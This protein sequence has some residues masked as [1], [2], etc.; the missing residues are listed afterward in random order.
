[1]S[2]RDMCS[3]MHATPPFVLQATHAFL[4]CFAG[5][6]ASARLWIRSH[7]SSP[8]DVM[9]SPSACHS[10]AVTT[11]ECPA[12]EARGTYESQTSQ[13]CTSQSITF[14]QDARWR[15]FPLPVVRP[16]RAAAAA[17]PPSPSASAPS[18][19]IRAPSLSPPSP[20]PLRAGLGLGFGFGLQ[21][22][23]AAE[24]TRI[25]RAA[26]WSL[27][28]PLESTPKDR[29][30]FPFRSARRERSRELRESP[31]GLSLP[32]SPLPLPLPRS[33]PLPP[34]RFSSGLVFGSRGSSRPC[35]PPCGPPRNQDEEEAGWGRP[36]T[37]T[38]TPTPAA[39]R[40]RRRRSRSFE[41]APA[42]RPLS[43]VTCRSR[44][45]RSPRWRPWGWSPC[46]EE[47]R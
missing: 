28:F 4:R 7:P 13:T 6:N 1:M 37:P 42:R 46:T 10:N 38:P 30:C 47:D 45:S 20:P 29:A 33:T 24:E 40:R 19:A 27:P 12:H 34:L 9:W 3:W 14:A 21:A 2:S 43:S 18:S 22:T 31:A 25:R 11:P 39:T 36:P 17:A 32:R 41:A 5:W 23:R 16:L 26:W 15:S 35:W 44:T 8:H